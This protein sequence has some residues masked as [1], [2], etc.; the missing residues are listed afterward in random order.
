MLKILNPVWI[1]FA[2]ALAFVSTSAQATPA[3]YQ[4]TSGT[5]QLRA[6]N[7]VTGQSVLAGP[8]VVSVPLGGT[9]VE[10]DSMTGMLSDLQMIPAGDFDLDLDPVQAVLSSITVSNAMLINAPGATA[11]VSGGGSFNI[12]TEMSADVSGVFPDTTPFPSTLF[13]SS[14][15]QA[16]GT[17]ILDGGSLQLGIFGVNIATFGTASNPQ[18]QDIQVKADFLFLS[19]VVPEPGT[20]L[21]LG[22]GIATLAGSRPN[23]RD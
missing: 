7:T 11:L 1:L 16:T 14:T 18:S 23:R 5:V 3:T 20:A 4:F 8:T 10:Y 22:L 2:L 6:V 19:T 17:L 15:S 12:D 13:T 9:F 21:L